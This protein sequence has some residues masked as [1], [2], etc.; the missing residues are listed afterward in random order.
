M[1]TRVGIAPKASNLMSVGGDEW[2]ALRGQFDP[3][4]CREGVPFILT[5]S[6]TG[7][8]R[9]Y[10]IRSRKT[11]KQRLRFFHGFITNY[12]ES[13]ISTVEGVLQQHGHEHAPSDD[14]NRLLTIWKQ[15]I[16]RLTQRS[17]YLIKPQICRQ[18]HCTG[19]NSRKCIHTYACNRNCHEAMRLWLAK[20]ISCNIVSSIFNPHEEIRDLFCASSEKENEHQHDLGVNLV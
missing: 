6:G 10:R 15:N 14:T 11:D 7:N 12:L 3:T 19:N 2:E 1:G 8:L 17:E 18:G 13:R 9:V 5:I 16:F 20:S 4:K